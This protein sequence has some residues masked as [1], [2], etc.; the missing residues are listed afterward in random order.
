MTIDNNNTYKIIYIITYQNQPFLAGFLVCLLDE[1]DLL[2]CVV[3]LFRST[4]P[5]AGVSIVPLLDL[6][7]LER[8][9]ERLLESILGIFII[10]DAGLSLLDEPLLD[11]DLDF[12]FS[13]E[14]K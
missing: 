5:D 1:L 9:L 6:E 13:S 11:L 12:G 7:I 14:I 2:G 10:P 3:P 8:L 4:G